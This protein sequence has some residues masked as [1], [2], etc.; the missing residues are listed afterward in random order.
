MIYY[1]ISPVL[2]GIEQKSHS[3]QVRTQADSPKRMSRSE[4]SD[5]FSIAQKYASLEEGKYVSE[6]AGKPEG[7]KS[8]AQRRLQF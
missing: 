3:P 6:Q 4:V 5:R 2:P 1:T 7:Q 8:A